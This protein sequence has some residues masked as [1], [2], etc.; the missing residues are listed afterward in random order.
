MNSKLTLYWEEE[1]SERKIDRETDI[2]Y[3][4]DWK[5]FLIFDK[6]KIDKIVSQVH[7]ESWLCMAHNV[8]GC[9][10]FSKRT[11]G[12]MFFTTIYNVPK[13]DDVLKIY[14]YVK[15]KDKG[16]VYYRIS[17]SYHKKY[18]FIVDIDS[19][20]LEISKSIAK[21]IWFPEKGSK[22]CGTYDYEE[23]VKKFGD[24]RE[25]IDKLYNSGL[26]EKCDDKVINEYAR[27][28][29]IN[30]DGVWGVGSVVF[31]ITDV[32]SDAVE[33]Y[34]EKIYNTIYNTNTYGEVKTKGSTIKVIFKF[35]DYTD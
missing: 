12:Y 7:K 25:V 30:I 23:A 22:K 29:K 19:Y 35:E 16:R 1:E 32:P 26:G 13:K 4:G 34:A 2:D 17:A 10:H 18:K 21:E 8:G 33:E 15:E 11:Y 6:R 24:F 20:G 14:E 3:E 5:H 28:Y 27:K 31:T 9:L